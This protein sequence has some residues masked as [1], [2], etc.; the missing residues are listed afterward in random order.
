MKILCALAMLTLPLMAI[1]QDYIESS[2]FNTDYRG[3][4]RVMQYKPTDDGGFVS[5]NGK[6]LYTRALYGGPTLF[7]IETSD[8]PIFA[9]YHKQENRNYPFYG[10]CSTARLCV[11][12]QSLIARRFISVVNDGIF[13]RIRHGETG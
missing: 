11:L 6:N 9:A 2:T 1:S 8:M 5:H 7:R 10:Y 13:F 12:I 3:A 4:K